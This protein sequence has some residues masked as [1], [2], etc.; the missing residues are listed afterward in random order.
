MS[1]SQGCTDDK[2]VVVSFKEA[3]KQRIGQ[4]RFQM[5]FTD[6]VSVSLV[7]D[8]PTAEATSVSTDLMDGC[9]APSSCQVAAKPADQFNI[10]TQLSGDHGSGGH[11]SGD[12]TAEPASD[13]RTD[14][15]LGRPA[16]RI[17]SQRFVVSVRGEFA[18]QRLSRN[19]MSE[20]RGAAMQACGVATDVIVEVSQQPAKQAA[21]P[22]D[23]LDDGNEF[24]RS[25]VA[26][27][28]SLGSATCSLAS[29]VEPISYRSRESADAQTS[30]DRDP[31][32][33]NPVMNRGRQSVSLGRRATP[34]QRQ[35][36]QERQSAQGQSA[37]EG[38]AAQEQQAAQGHGIADGPRIAA[39]TPSRARLSQGQTNS[40]DSLITQGFQSIPSG[41]PVK[42]L[43]ANE[44][45]QPNL[46]YLDREEAAPSSGDR[47]SDSRV[48]TPAPRESGHSRGPKHQDGDS[49]VRAGGV[50]ARPDATS[51]EPMSLESFIVSDCNRL[52][53]TAATMVIQ[54]P[55][56]ASPLFLAGPTGVG[57]SHLLCALADSL[58]RRHRM[59]RVVVSSA[60][61]FT[62]EFIAAIRESTLTSFRRRYRDVDALLI[63]DVQFLGKKTATLREMLYTVEDLTKAGRPMIFSG[64]KT[65]N[66]M[67][68]LCGELAGRMSA[69]LV[70]SIQPMDQTVRESLLRRTAEQRCD[71]EWPDPVI[72]E[73]SGLI[74]GDGR[75]IQGV[76]NLVATL[77]RMYDRMPTMDEIRQFGGDLLRASTPIVS[78]ST[79]ERAVCDTFHLETGQ[80]QT[81][82][83]SRV[84]S[85]PRMLAMYLS[86]ELTSSA[87]AEISRHYGGR[88]H[89]TAIMA[90][91]RVRQW[92]DSGKMIGRGVG[93]MSAKDALAR[94]E[95][96]LRT[97]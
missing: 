49:G 66:D 74:A 63:D 39:G 5:W 59:R 41:R 64:S 25:N 12:H 84:V 4:E 58:R 22:L 40:L 38:Q 11:V 82:V 26:V 55:R 44:P 28:G 52:A 15:D 14:G 86:R 45:A 1:A 57:K 9:D 77:Q 97:G 87:F 61:R 46:P 30:R 62:N 94:I 27:A 80:L 81:M 76:V 90:S 42:R 69:G 93:A 53:Q 71:I 36:A 83:Q 47:S 67:S 17:V 95:N 79:I 21:L 50:S 34:R 13:V 31:A 92:L 96:L 43:R 88:S 24:E 18:Q 32:A 78:L 68:G 35:L 6:Q 60:E 29:A 89:S 56:A 7:A 48:Q 19:L 8:A 85:E 72:D 2:A 75:A 37:Q 91:K 51:T 20:M 54:S 65:P 33:R 16:S 10:N 73:I 23:G 3:L 70:C